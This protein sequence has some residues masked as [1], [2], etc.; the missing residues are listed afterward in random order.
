[1]KFRYKILMVN[2]IVLSLSLGVVGY[3]MIRRNFDLA[4]ETQL[5][6]AI[7]E[8]NLVQSSVEYELLEQI[9]SGEFRIKESLSEIGGRVM[10]GM[11]S[12]T[13]SFYIRYG[14]EY[15]YSGDGEERLIP[16]SLFAGLNFGGKNYIICENEDQYFVYVTSY[17]ELDGVGLSIV[18]KQDIS[19]SYYMLNEQIGYF[20][21]LIVGV[22]LVASVIVYFLC[23]YLTG[24]LEKL[25]QVTAEIAEGNYDIHVDATSSDEVGQL[26]EN[27]NVMAD[28]VQA[29]VEELKDMIHRRE[30]FVADFT[31]EIKTPIT[32]IIAC[33]D[34]VRSMEMPREEQIRALT[35]VFSEGKR[36]EIMSQ[37]LFQLIYLKQYE[38]EKAP[39]N[40]KNLER[41][42]I[43]ITAPILEQ[44]QI[45]LKTDVEQAVIHGDK[46][47][48]NTVFINLIDNA[49]KASKEGSVIEL[50]GRSLA[51]EGEKGAG[52]VN[53][54]GA[55][56]DASSAK[57]RKAVYE[58]TVV[59]SGIGMSQED[60]AHICDEFY[61]VDKSRSRRE[62]GAGLGLSLAALILDKHQ[63]VLQVESEIGKGTT[64]KVVFYDTEVTE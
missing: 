14:E 30:Q 2:I 46:E 9:N 26:G 51:E 18:S 10:D 59:D 57:G 23:K 29:H 3:L 28:A 62:G 22:V 38:I 52:D 44:K 58:L 34:M 35:Y 48:L 12:G 61:M 42:I 49:R 8:N 60:I 33:S 36:L 11:I 5:K 19:D 13:S 53:G 25:N 55:K 17:S 50:R 37:K 24:P 64:M 45:T 4:R 15:A 39:V 1:M 40:T 32:T 63:A 47:L 27:V 31:H 20:R 7:I 56:I 16:D 43:R 54:E 21:L 6:N 41:E